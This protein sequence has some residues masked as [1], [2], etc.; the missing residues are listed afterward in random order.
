[1]YARKKIY[2]WLNTLPSLVGQDIPKE[3]RAECITTL[4]ENDL[5]SFTQH[6]SS[7]LH[8]IEKGLPTAKTLYAKELLHFFSTAPSFEA[9]SSEIGLQAYMEDLSRT[10]CSSSPPSPAFV[11]QIDKMVSFATLEPICRT[12]QAAQKGS[13]AKALRDIHEGDKKAQ[14]VLFLTSPEDKRQKDQLLEKILPSDRY[15][16]STRHIEQKSTDTTPKAEQIRQ[17]LLRERPDLINIL[18]CNDVS[19]VAAVAK[20]LGIPVINISA[21]FDMRFDWNTTSSSDMKTV[22]PS[23]QDPIANSTIP[24]TIKKKDIEEIGLLVGHKFEK[25]YTPEKISA[26]RRKFSISPEQKVV[27]ISCERAPNKPDLIEKLISDYS[28]KSQPLHIIALCTDTYQEHSIREKM[29]KRLSNKPHLQLSTYSNIDE[30]QEAIFAHVADLYITKPNE[31]R[32]LQLYKAGTRTIFDQREPSQ[33]LNSNVIVSRGR[34]SILTDTHR[35]GIR[36]KKEVQQ[37]RYRPDA[38]SCIKASERY[39]KL[40]TTLLNNTGDLLRSWYHS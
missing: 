25:V 32:I 40:V 1:M 38:I 27:V 7:F 4:Q 18:S 24:D 14:H 6:I 23:T 22:A 3:T 17:L 31:R 30:K 19:T 28:D 15:T 33:I 34:A 36:V 29:K 35:L 10:L 21:G 11:S 39:T 16:F 12:H 37:L 26:L 9:L 5:A 8:P 13:I 20:E 2:D